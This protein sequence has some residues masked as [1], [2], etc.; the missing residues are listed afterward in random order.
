MN[1]LDANTVKQ[2]KTLADKMPIV[3]RF[4]IEKHIMTQQELDEM[5]FVGAEK[6]PDGTYMYKAPVQ[7][8]VNHLR[9]LKKAWKRSG[10]EGA[11]NYIDKINSLPNL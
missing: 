11:S 1:V 2:L 10:Y 7:I 5:G 9:A 6:L 3:W 4:C 8:A